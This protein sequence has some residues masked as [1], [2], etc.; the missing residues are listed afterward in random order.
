MLRWIFILFLLGLVYYY[1]YPNSSFWHRQPIHS[2][3]YGLIQDPHLIT[4]KQ[5]AMRPNESWLF[6]T[7]K[8]KDYIGTLER[9]KNFLN[10]NYE[11][12][13]II[14]N[15][16]LDWL[17][18]NHHSFILAIQ[19][20][21]RQEILGTIGGFITHLFINGEVRKAYYIDIL[22]IQKKYRQK[23]YAVKLMEK[24]IEKWRQDSGE[25]M[26]FKL[27]TVKISPAPDFTLTYY[28]YQRENV[29]KLSPSYHLDPINNNNIQQAFNYY[30]NQMKKYPIREVQ[31][32]KSFQKWIL[33]NNNLT[34]SFLFKKADKI[35]GFVNL[36]KNYYW[37]NGKKVKVIDLIYLLGNKI[38]LFPYL[39]ERYSDYQYV[40]T[41]DI[42]DHLD[43][44]SLYKFTQLY[45]T[46]Y[47]FYNYEL[48]NKY[49][50]SDIGIHHF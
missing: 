11:K 24:I 29:G 15:I 30:Q 22:C 31:T 14:S 37:H 8:S 45:Q 40:I 28:L 3:T 26:L 42:Q 2:D 10:Q 4:P 44:I 1:F 21:K 23:G 33:G 48:L 38:Q 5:M 17:L 32:L 9:I 41:L 36:M 46:R 34:E 50:K 19:N 35:E 7:N 13:L 43:I 27:D 20:N 12:D 25:I 47:Y 39:L 16:Y 49:K 18:Q 6:L